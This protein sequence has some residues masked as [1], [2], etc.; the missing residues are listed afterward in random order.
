MIMV[1]KSPAPNKKNEK[2]FSYWEYVVNDFFDL[3]GPVSDKERC[4]LL[5]ELKKGGPFQDAIDTHPTFS[6]EGKLVTAVQH[7]DIKEFWLFKVCD[8]KIIKHRIKR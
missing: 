4:P 8:G 2:L 6:I 5:E 1:H 3:H 7:T